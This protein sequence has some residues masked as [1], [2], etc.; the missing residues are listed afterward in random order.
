M[1]DSTARQ[2]HGECLQS[3]NNRTY[4]IQNCLPKKAQKLCARVEYSLTLILLPSLT[5]NNLQNMQGLLIQT[6]L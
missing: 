3:V 1:P 2:L 4:E 6:S 5:L